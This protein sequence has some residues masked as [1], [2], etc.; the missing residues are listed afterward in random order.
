MAVAKSY[1]T[2]TWIWGVGHGYGSECPTRQSS[3]FRK[4]RHR[5]KFGHGYENL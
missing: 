4:C 1:V 2:W 3:N 5:P